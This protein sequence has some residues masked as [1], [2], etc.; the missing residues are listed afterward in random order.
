MGCCGNKREQW[1]QMEK[2][3]LER[4]I[5]WG[6]GNSFAQAERD[7]L[8]KVSLEKESQ[9]KDQLGN[10]IFSK[11]NEPKIFEYTGSSTLALTG[12]NT[13]SLYHFG[14]PG[15]RLEIAYEDAFALMAESELKRV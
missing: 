13:R 12:V 4:P 9:E 6:A 1:N 8:G 2:E 5:N 10:G 15:H 7:A 11:L 3:V 14:F